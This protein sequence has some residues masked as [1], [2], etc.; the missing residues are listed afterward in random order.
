MWK[1]ES[2][3]APPKSGGAPGR[4]DR[5]ACP[6]CGRFMQTHPQEDIA[7]RFRHL[8]RE[9]R[10]GV[11]PAY[12]VAPRTEVPVIADGALEP[13]TWGLV[14]RFARAP[15]D[16]PRPINARAEGLVTSRLFGSLLTQR[17]CLIPADG[18]Y[19][20]ATEQ[21]RKQPWRLMFERGDIFGFAGLWD[22][23]SGPAGP[24]R[25]F[26][27]ITVP[28]SPFA[29]LYHDRMPAIL[30][31]ADEERWLSRAVSQADALGRLQSYPAEAMRAYPV[32]PRVGSPR[33]QGPECV[34]PIAAPD[35]ARA[36][37]QRD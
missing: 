4:R 22:E 29:A 21:G 14:P 30:A 2:A 6:M 34:A 3:V 16:G 12:N 17:R 25:T 11:A 18:Y 15:E 10:T 5:Y 35:A 20:W 36:R 19:E 27:I 1:G 23:W 33:F 37:P 24:L 7:V 31:P 13:M 28:A 32:D 8:V 26:T 9:W